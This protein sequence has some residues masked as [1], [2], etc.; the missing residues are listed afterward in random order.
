[1][2]QSI[3][4]QRLL[5][6]LATAFGVLALLLAAVGLYGVLSYAVARRT[7]E[8][9][10]RVALG[11]Q[12]PDLIRMVLLDALRLVAIGV[13][14]GLPLALGATRLLVSQLHGVSPA[15]PLSIAIAVSVLGGSAVVAGLL[16]ALRASRVS[17]IEAL[18]AE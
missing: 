16:P 4:Q 14:I 9:G 1:M 6:Q 10:V 13:V 8:M 11:A 7:G 15:D 3:V 5:A 17:P 2:M 18:R 12:Q